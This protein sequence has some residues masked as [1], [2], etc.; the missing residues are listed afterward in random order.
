[1]DV[2]G[3]CDNDGARENYRERQI[4]HRNPDAVATHDCRV[5]VPKEFEAKGEPSGGEEE[6]DEVVER[7]IFDPIGA[8]R[9]RV[10]IAVNASNLMRFRCGYAYAVLAHAPSHTGEDKRDERDVGAQDNEGRGNRTE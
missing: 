3:E 8:K 10:G 7:R 1:M 9:W 6:G 2:D 4:A 5:R